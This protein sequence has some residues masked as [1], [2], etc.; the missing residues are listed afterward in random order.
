MSE[1]VKYGCSDWDSPD[2]EP[3]VEDI[4]DD[5]ELASAQDTFEAYISDITKVMTEEELKDLL[6]RFLHK[7]DSSEFVRKEIENM[8]E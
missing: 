1:A 2:Y 4:I 5:Y 6:K 7:G 8:Q 3:I